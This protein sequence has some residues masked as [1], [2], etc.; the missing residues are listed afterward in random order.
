MTVEIVAHRQN[1]AFARAQRWPHVARAPRAARG[2][3]RI[4]GTRCL[5]AGDRR[6]RRRPRG[7]ASR[8]ARIARA[9]DPSPR[10]RGGEARRTRAPSAGAR[11]PLRARRGTSVRVSNAAGS[12]VRG[13]NMWRA[14]RR[15]VPPAWIAS[16]LPSSRVRG[17]TDASLL[18]GGE[19]GAL[20]LVGDQNGVHRLERAGRTLA[21]SP[22]ASH[23]GG[24]FSLALGERGDDDVALAVGHAPDDERGRLDAP[25]RAPRSPAYPHTHVDGERLESSVGTP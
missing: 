1:R 23:D 3:P 24:H 13:G 16:R 17:F 7:T 5:P 25:S 9:R 22:C 18:H 14:Q 6:T 8:S 19:L 4:A 12:G 11:R 10:H 20:V 21:P 2:R 15:S